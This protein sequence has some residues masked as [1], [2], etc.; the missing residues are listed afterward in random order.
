MPIIEDV[1]KYAERAKTR[2]VACLVADALAL[3]TVSL[4]PRPRNGPV[5]GSGGLLSKLGM[6]DR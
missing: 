6:Q 2:A 3:K 5:S 1:K 4:V